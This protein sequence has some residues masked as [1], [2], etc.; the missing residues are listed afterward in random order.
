MTERLRRQC[1]LLAI[2]GAVYRGRKPAERLRAGR[3]AATLYFFAVFFTVFN[4]VL[5]L[6]I[7]LGFNFRR[8]IMLQRGN[9]MNRPPVFPIE[10][11]QPT[12]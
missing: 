1:L 11:N 7:K 9:P 2:F 3:A 10:R 5:T 4:D 6:L 12:S 8:L